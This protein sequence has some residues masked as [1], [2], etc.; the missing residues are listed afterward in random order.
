MSEEK[1]YHNERG[2]S[3]ILS[4]IS[5]ILFM[6]L[7]W[8]ITHDYDPHAADKK[9]LPEIVKISSSEIS[10][11]A[12]SLQTSIM[13]MKTSKI[14]SIEELS[15]ANPSEEGY[16]NPN[17]YSSECELFHPLGGG[18]VYRIPDEDWLDED[19][20]DSPDYKKWLFPDNVCIKDL[21]EID[22]QPCNVDGRDNEEIIMLLPYV[23][24]SVCKALNINF[25]L[26]KRKD[27]IPENQECVYGESKYTGTFNDGFRI[28]DKNGIFARQIYGCVKVLEKNCPGTEDHNVFF[29][30]LSPR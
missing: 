30:A 27:P 13:R 11:Y 26:Q 19:K 1:I 25:G 16:D 10:Q 6:M 15:F 5:A 14:D 9:N 23:T 21:P 8:V 18:A 29:F 3:R 2:S 7:A 17:C 28:Q 12:L 20:K 22:F 24:D 4:F